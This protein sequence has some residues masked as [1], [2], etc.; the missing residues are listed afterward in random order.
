MLAKKQFF[1]K[2]KQFSQKFFKTH[3]VNFDNPKAL[4][5][6]GHK[7]Q[8]CSKIRWGEQSKT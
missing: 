4:K 7:R 8:K 2:N 6:A 5:I 3:F 1:H